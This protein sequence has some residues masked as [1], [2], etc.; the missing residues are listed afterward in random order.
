MRKK[1]LNIIQLIVL[2]SL[3]INLKKVTSKQIY[4]TLECRDKVTNAMELGS[5]VIISA[6]RVKEAAK[7][8]QWKLVAFNYLFN[9]RAVKLIKLVMQQC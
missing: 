4:S 7:M 9:C 5:H 1:Y 2:A 8:C 6:E 3:L